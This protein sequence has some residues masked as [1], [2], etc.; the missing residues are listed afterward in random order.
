MIGQN[1]LPNQPGVGVED[2]AHQYRITVAW[3]QFVCRNGVSPA[4]VFSN[5]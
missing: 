5:I 1:G 4:F 3:H 2:L